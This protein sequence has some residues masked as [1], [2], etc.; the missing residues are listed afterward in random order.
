M[1][2]SGLEKVM[3]CG[4][5][6][7]PKMLTG[8]KFP[9]NVRALRF[10]VLE[11]LRAVVGEMVEYKDLIMFLNNISEKVSTWNTGLTM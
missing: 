8:K 10:V 7:I 2:N 6:D 9:V 5:A 1:A 11:Q 3:N 4:F